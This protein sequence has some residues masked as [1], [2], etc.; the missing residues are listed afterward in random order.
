MD[1]KN[2]GTEEQTASFRV[3]FLTLGEEERQK[4]EI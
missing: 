1:R 4:R 3:R 2:S